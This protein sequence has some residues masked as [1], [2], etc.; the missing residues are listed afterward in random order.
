[1]S[2]GTAATG[3]AAGAGGAHIGPTREDPAAA[4]QNCR[5]ARRAG[6]RWTIN[7]SS[8]VRESEDRRRH[9]SLE[10]GEERD[11]GIVIE[12][13]DAAVTLFDTIRIHAEAAVDWALDS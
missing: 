13:G 2:P 9:R 8:G 11:Q 3:H 4:R 7:L 10:R 12:D 5:T 1:M 6:K